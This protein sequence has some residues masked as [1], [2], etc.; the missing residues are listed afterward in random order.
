MN[1]KYYTI[2]LISII[3]IGILAIIL[4]LFIYPIKLNSA[5]IM[6]IISFVFI[7]SMAFFISYILTYDINQELK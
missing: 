7:I 1:D 4:L 3:I 6:A 5:E 2:I